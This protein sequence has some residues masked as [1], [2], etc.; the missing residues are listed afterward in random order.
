MGIF[1]SLIPNYDLILTYG[2]GEPVINAYKSLGARECIPI[3]NALDATTHYPVSPNSR[4]TG[5]LGF[6]GNRMPDR[7][8]RVEEFLFR[9]ATQLPNYNR[10]YESFSHWRQDKKNSK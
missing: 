5:D 1:D 10:K 8:T 3:Y 4:F 6:L 2:G 9:A 7:E